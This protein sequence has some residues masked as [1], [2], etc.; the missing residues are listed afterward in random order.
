M[1]SDKRRHLQVKTSYIVACGISDVGRERS[2][3]EDSMF[4]DEAGRFLLLADGM[5]GHERGA[6]ASATAIK[7]IKEYFRPEL[8]SDELQNITGGSGIPS[9]IL[10]FLSLVDTAVNN[11]NSTLYERNREEGLA[12]YMGTTV[13]GLVPIEG[14][15]V[16]WFHV[17]DSRLYRWRDSLLKS[18]TTD[19]SARAEWLSGGRTGSQ[20]AKN[21]ITRAI[22]PKEAVSAETAWDN[23][24]Q[25]DIYIL[26][27]DGLSD[28]LKEDQITQILNAETEKSVADI[29]TRLIDSANKAGGK[30]N[31]SAVVC[32]IC[33]PCVQSL[34][35]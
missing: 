8:V 21:I 9:E 7:V 29:A 15:Y 24:Q 22:G 32:R 3:N 4:L 18:L 1:E 35:L 17:G 13:V 28:M 12:R 16:L 5:G 11:A 34:T 23:W 30:D 2:E 27:S 6:E 20:P 14:R 26:C 10:C 33:S 25:D 19:H 31:V